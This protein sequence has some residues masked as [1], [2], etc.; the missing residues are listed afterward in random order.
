MGIILL[1]PTRL[2]TGVVDITTTRSAADSQDNNK[3][4]LFDSIKSG[5]YFK[6]VEKKK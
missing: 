6:L 4:D 1:N 2:T 3:G 5:S